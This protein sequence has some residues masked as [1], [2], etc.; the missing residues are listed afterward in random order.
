M[1]Q[2]VRIGVSFLV[3][4]AQTRKKAR[5]DL[6]SGESLASPPPRARV[7]FSLLRGIEDFVLVFMFRNFWGDL[8]YASHIVCLFCNG[9]VFNNFSCWCSTIPNRLVPRGPQFHE[10]SFASMPST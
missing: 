6:P 3:M 9:Q 10:N 1:A 8:E 4:R 7:G 2:L 5:R